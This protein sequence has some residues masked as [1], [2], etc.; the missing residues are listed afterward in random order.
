MAG[1]RNS[2]A[3]MTVFRQTSQQVEQK[4]EKNKIQ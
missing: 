3:T 2:M 4:W 1:I